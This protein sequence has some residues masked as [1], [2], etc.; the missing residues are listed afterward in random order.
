MQTGHISKERLVAFI[1][2]RGTLTEEEYE[3]LKE[4]AE[5]VRIV[6]NAVGMKSKLPREQAGTVQ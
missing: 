6:V 3:H 1:M 4:C 2:S 5:C